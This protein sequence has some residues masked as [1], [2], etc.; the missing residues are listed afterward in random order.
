MHDS[1]CHHKNYYPMCVS[2]F[3]FNA[4]PTIFPC[5]R[6]EAMSPCIT[7]GRGNFASSLIFP[8]LWSSFYVI[9]N[10]SR[11]LMCADDNVQAREC[12]IIERELISW[13]YF[14][15]AFHS[16]RTFCCPNISS[17]PSEVF[18]LKCHVDNSQC[19]KIS[20]FIRVTNR[21]VVWHVNLIFKSCHRSIAF[22]RHMSHVFLSLALVYVIGPHTVGS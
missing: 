18:P 7:C 6:S 20:S 19:W 11:S 22:S 21:L 17:H 10:K 12:V 15:H 16:S 14:L 8:V 3:S 5:A 2:R 9:L 1:I 13:G 4:I